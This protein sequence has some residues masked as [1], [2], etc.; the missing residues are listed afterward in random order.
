MYRPLSV[1]ATL[2]S[3]AVL[4]ASALI[5][6]A[7]AGSA[8]AASSQAPGAPGTASDWVPGDKDGFGTAIAAPPSK[9]W[10]TLTAATLS[11]IYY[12]RIDTPSTRDTQLVVTDGRTFT[13]RERPPPPTGSGCSTREPGLPADRHGQVGQVP[14]SP[15]P[16]SPTRP[17]STVLV[18]V[19]FRVADRPAATTSTSCTTR[20]SAMTGDDDT[21]RTGRGALRRHRRHA[22]RRRARLQRLRQDLQ[23][24]PGTQRRVDRPERPITAWTGRYNAGQPGNVV[25]PGQ[26]RLTGLAGRPAPDAGH[27]LRHAP[28]T[29]AADTARAVA[30]L[31]ASPPRPARVRAGWHRY[32]DGLRPVPRSSAA[33]RRPSTTSRRWCSPPARTRRSAA[34]SSPRRAGPGP[35]RTCCSRCPSTTRCGRATCTRSPPRL[36][37]MGDRAAAGRALD[38]LCDRAAAPR[39][40]VSRRTAGSTASRC[41]AACR[42]TRCRS[43]PC[44]PGSWAAPA[45]RTGS[46]SAGPRTS[47]SPTARARPASAGRTRPA[48]RRPRSR[49]RS[50]GSWCGADIARQQRR[51]RPRAPL[52]GDGR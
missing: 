35:G 23:R 8:V 16:T 17:R 28:T 2:S 36:I 7:P 19:T 51:R 11:E 10:Y 18:D 38:Y 40:L 52:P 20:P 6:V 31:P 41:S 49:P 1:V 37:A 43:R 39:R 24:L 42:W 30:A 48:T 21:G 46:T 14:R 12:P 45:P 3:A 25:Q 13:D 34:G 44:W 32:L 50:P 22:E 29:A 27:R 9:V 5:A 47:S 4:A 33:V 15:R 26:T